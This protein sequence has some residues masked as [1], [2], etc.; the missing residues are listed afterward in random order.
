[1]NIGE[2]V[3]CVLYGSYSFY[4]SI[5][6]RFSVNIPSS[7]FYFNQLY[8]LILGLPADFF[9]SK[10]NSTNPRVSEVKKEEPVE[11]EPMS[12]DDPYDSQH[13]YLPKEKKAPPPPKVNSVEG[14]PEGFFDDPKL[15][16][17]VCRISRMF[18]L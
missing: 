7:S 12:V 13:Y 16:A 5:I 9:D 18:T 2:I 10:L 1:M 11:E 6:N 3:W 17:K 14:L 8:Y 15:D 4:V